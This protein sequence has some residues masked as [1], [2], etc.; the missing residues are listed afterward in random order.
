ML[1]TT[2]YGVLTVYAKASQILVISHHISFLASFPN[3][4][5]GI[6][7]LDLIILKLLACF[8]YHAKGQLWLQDIA[9]ETAL[10]RQ[11]GS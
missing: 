1:S 11:Y 5:N 9:K 3:Y 8:I 2:H 6:I 7:I 4:K 10:T